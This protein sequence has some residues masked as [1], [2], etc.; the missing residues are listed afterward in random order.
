MEKAQEKATTI[1]QPKPE[2]LAEM[3]QYQQGVDMATRLYNVYVAGVGHVLGID[4]SKQM[5]D[6]NAFVERPQ[7]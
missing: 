4:F 2:V 5:F 7:Q 1:P 6:G 3:R